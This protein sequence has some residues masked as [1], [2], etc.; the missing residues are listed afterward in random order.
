VSPNV[1]LIIGDDIGWTDFGFMESSRTLQTNQG[2]MLIQDVVQTPNLDSIAASGVLFR[3]AHSTG[4]ICKPALRTLLSAG[5]LH[6]F[7]WAALEQ[8][9]EAAPGIGPIPRREEVQYY[10]TLPRELG[11][12]G[13]RSWEGGKMWEG[14]YAMAGFTHGLATAIGGTL[15]SVGD[16]FGRSDWDTAT[17]GSMGAPGVPC[18][19]LAP[20][21]QFLD[22]VEGHRFFAWVAPS[23][24]HVP[25]DA[26]QA[27]RQHYEDLGLQPYEVD[28]LA[29][30][31]WL[32]EIVGEVIGE[33]EERALRDD[34]L[35]L[36]VSDNGWGLGLQFIPGSGRGKGTLYDLGFR[37]PVIVQWPGRIPEG[38]VY[39][40]LVSLT[41]VVPTIYDYVGADGVPGQEGVSLRPRIEG[42]SPLART[43]VIG[44][45][46]TFGA[47]LRTDTWRYLRF[48]SDG[49][50][51]LYRID[52]DPLEEVDLAAANPDLLAT[53]SRRVDQ[54]VI[55]RLTPPDR[56]EITG[57]L[58]HRD[59]RAPLVGS[60]LRIAGA[61]WNAIAGPDGSFRLGPLPFDSYLL[62]GEGRLDDV[63]GLG[64]V[65]FIPLSPALVARGLHLPV[66]ATLTGA[67]PGTFGGRIEG[68]LEDALGEPIAGQTVK[69]A[70]RAAGRSVRIYTLTQADG[71]YRAENL[72]LTNYRVTTTVP[73]G[74]R[75][76]VAS[77]I[78]V[79]DGS[80]VPLDL[81]A[82]R[83]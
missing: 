41:D 29:N 63:E 45:H 66:V 16:D 35:L 36:Y 1:V 19:A 38:M 23:L 15:S 54:W 76:V 83:R 14:T 82:E 30:V 28:Y 77:G 33:L 40:D 78:P 24:P 67:V 42:G 27:Y 5:G 48:E 62:T 11:R 71:S 69:V 51:E 17:C 18:P 80:P 6:S 2:E 37:T 34:T 79:V 57:R 61:K 39:D 55:E 70:G 50:E 75:R 26:P 65:K 44:F 20:F 10:R 21:R 52:L 53:F 32:D 9:L 64:A 74:C 81:V 59:T 13:F 43:E 31:T 47:F 60:R 58:V 22:E 4:S 25:Y 12:I 7:Q 72:A 68:T 8:G 56:I 49:H 3:N 46:E 73:P